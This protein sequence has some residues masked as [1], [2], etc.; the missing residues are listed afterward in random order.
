MN[1]VYVFLIAFGLGGLLGSF[2]GL[3]IGAG[4]VIRQVQSG[5]IVIGGHIY[6]CKDTGPV[7]R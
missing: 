5:R 3:I 6:F 2:M 1:P 4:S 7:V